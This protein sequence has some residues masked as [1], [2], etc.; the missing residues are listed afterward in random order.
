MKDKSKDRIPDLV[1]VPEDAME[2]V[3]ELADEELEGVAGGFDCDCKGKKPKTPGKAVY[4]F[5]DYETP[6]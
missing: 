4:I 5:E 1:Q 3:R 6:L 2:D